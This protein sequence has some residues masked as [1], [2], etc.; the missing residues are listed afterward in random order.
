M[1]FLINV[2][3][4]DKVV[5]PGEEQALNLAQ[6]RLG[7][8]GTQVEAI[9]GFVQKVRELHERELSD[10]EATNVLKEAVAKLETAGIPFSAI[11]PKK[12]TVNLNSTQNSYSKESF[13]EKVKN[14][15]S[16]AGKEI[17]E[18]ALLL[19]YAAQNPNTPTWAKTTIYAALAYF[20]SPIDGIPDVLPVVGFTDDFTALIAAIA[21][22]TMYITPEVKEQA[23]QKIEDWCLNREL[24]LASIARLI[25]PQY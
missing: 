22:V 18:K 21:V 9:E 20:I 19:Y 10:K 13:W 12:I 2:V 5:K 14:F 25:S 4:V 11:D 16:A 23:K 24:I 1:F 3:W 15:A 17:I 8:S 7:I 6:D